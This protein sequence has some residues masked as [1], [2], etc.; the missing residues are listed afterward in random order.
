MTTGRGWRVL[1]E[2]IFLHSQLL[3]SIEQKRLNGEDIGSGAGIRRWV[4]KVATR[5]GNHPQLFKINT[6]PLETVT[7]DSM[8]NF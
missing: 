2:Y 3:K 6:P 1:P 8:P 4:E 5:L 7:E